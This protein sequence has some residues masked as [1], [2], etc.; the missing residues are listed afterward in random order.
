MFNRA[1]Y[2]IHKDGSLRIGDPED[3]SRRNHFFIIGFKTHKDIDAIIQSIKR[4]DHVLTP[5]F[6][7]RYGL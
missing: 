7:V 3:E 2:Y 6:Q 1:V 4:V 5:I